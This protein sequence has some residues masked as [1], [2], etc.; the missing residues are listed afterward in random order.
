MRRVAVPPRP[1]VNAFMSLFVWHSVVLQDARPHD[2]TSSSISLN[3]IQ[4][5]LLQY[6]TSEG[7]QAKTLICTVEFLIRIQRLYRTLNYIFCAG[8][9]VFSHGRIKRQLC[10][11]WW[12]K[13]LRRKSTCN[14]IFLPASLVMVQGAE[15]HHCRLW[16]LLLVC[17]HMYKVIAICDKWGFL[18]CSK[19]EF[20]AMPFHVR[21]DVLQNAEP[22]HCSSLSLS[23]R[24]LLRFMT[25]DCLTGQNLQ[26]V[27]E[28]SR[29]WD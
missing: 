19:P 20:I 10:S 6:V 7:P 16:S 23:L 18:R 8:P 25:S 24:Q 29:P 4:K 14:T 5:Q 17:V 11:V 3:G 13:A 15:P 2:C 1:G 21:Q 27:Y 12:L 28:E 22:H 9:Q 26:A